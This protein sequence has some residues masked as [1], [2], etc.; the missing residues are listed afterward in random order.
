MED[1][2]IHSKEVTPQESQGNKARGEMYGLLMAV[3][4]VH[5]AQLKAKS[6]SDFF[7]QV[8]DS[9]KRVDYVRFVWVGLAEKG[10][11]QIKP[12][13]FAGFEGGY[14]SSIKV[15]W[16]DS[17][18]GKGPTGMA[19]KTGQLYVMRD[20]ATDPKYDAWRK[21]ALKRGYSSSVALPLIHDPNDLEPRVSMRLRLEQYHAR[22]LSL[23][24]PLV[25]LAFQCTPPPCAR[26]IVGL[27]PVS[28][29]V[30]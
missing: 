19:I 30:P 21:E 24:L 22:F 18:Y 25:L 7:Q 17:E 6:E 13:A 20:T 3:N 12:V 16:D 1:D 15:T 11:F 8:C 23:L 26:C 27:P 5:R 2:S 14:L 10:S 9:L 29:S 28:S 4:D